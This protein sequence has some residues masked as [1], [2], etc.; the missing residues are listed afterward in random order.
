MPRTGP[1]RI[2]GEDWG[3]D[4][5]GVISRTLPAVPANTR[6]PARERPQRLQERKQTDLD[7]LNEDIAT[8]TTE[9]DQLVTDIANLQTIIDN[10]AP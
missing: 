2:D 6:N 3:T 1:F 10:A 5:A 7:Q 9:R 8:M 4:A